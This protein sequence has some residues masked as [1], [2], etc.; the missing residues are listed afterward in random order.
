M[1]TANIIFASCNKIIVLKLMFA[2]HILHCH[3]VHD[4]CSHERS[5]SV[6]CVPPHPSNYNI[7]PSMA[8]LL[9]SISCMAH[10]TS[11]SC[12]S[13]EALLPMPPLSPIP[14]SHPT[15]VLHIHNN[16]PPLPREPHTTHRELLATRLNHVYTV[17]DQH[18]H[19]VHD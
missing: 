11:S 8:T 7:Y 18:C 15:V 12:G 1:C 17:H 2:V 9:L 6:V 16:R 5:G 19:S 13:T 14:T 10:A 3:S 4:Y